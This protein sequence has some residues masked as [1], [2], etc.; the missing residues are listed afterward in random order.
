VYL[1]ATLKEK[2]SRA[3]TKTT[4]LQGC[5]FL[6]KRQNTQNERAKVSEAR[7]AK[8]QFMAGVT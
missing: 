6:L 8:K 5:S 3:D 4:I 1:F 2:G 7:I